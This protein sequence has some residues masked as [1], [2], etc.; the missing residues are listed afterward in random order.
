MMFFTESYKYR[1]PTVSTSTSIQAREP[2][3]PFHPLRPAQQAQGMI[4]TRRQVSWFGK[5]G[6]ASPVPHLH[7]GRLMP[8]TVLEYSYLYCAR[9][10]VQYTRE[11]TKSRT[12]IECAMHYAV[13]AYH[14]I[15]FFACPFFSFVTLLPSNNTSPTDM[16]LSPPSLLQFGG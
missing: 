14:T 10:R 11:P 12:V 2:R 13:L 15:A 5:E 6:S 16:D 3:T 7:W 1:T 9:V 8:C 4:S